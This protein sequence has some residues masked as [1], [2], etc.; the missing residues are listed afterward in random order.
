MLC[1]RIRHLLHRDS[2][3]ARGNVLD[4]NYRKKQEAPL[5][6]SAHSQVITMKLEFSRVSD[7]HFD[8]LILGRPFQGCLP[9]LN[10]ARI[11]FSAGVSFNVWVEGL[12]DG[13]RPCS[14]V[15]LIM[16]AS[17]PDVLFG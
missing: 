11:L 4:L 1:Y 7:F 12:S 2:V 10:V 5:L 16:V 17:A 8:S 3:Q 6:N 14:S 9:I 13:S 15:L